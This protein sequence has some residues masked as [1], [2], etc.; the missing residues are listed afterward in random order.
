MKEVPSPLNPVWISHQG[1]SLSGPSV[2]CPGKREQSQKWGPRPTPQ[3][4]PHRVILNSRLTRFRAL[5]L[6]NKG[7]DSSQVKTQAGWDTLP[8]LPAQGC[9]F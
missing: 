1:L 8:S 9:P 6:E 3:P 4:Q 7:Q 5:F 2:H